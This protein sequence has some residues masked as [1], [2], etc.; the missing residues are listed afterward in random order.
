MAP[1]VGEKGELVLEGCDADHEVKV[2]DALSLRAQSAPL[3]PEEFACFLID[4]DK[5]HAP[6][7]I[8]QLALAFPWIPGVVHALPQLGERNGRNREPL[9]PQFLQALLNPFM[10]VE[11]VDGSV[12]VHQVSER[13]SFGC[14]LVSI[15]RFS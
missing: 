3:L 10:A 2:A 15:K 4:A 7:E 13:H 9:S 14:S 12:C 11:P 6:Q 8:V 1:V 5:G